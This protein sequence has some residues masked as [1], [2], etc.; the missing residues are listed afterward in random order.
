MGYFGVLMLWLRM[1]MLG[2]NVRSVC[3]GISDR[4][5]DLWV[6]VRRIN[7]RA[8][9]LPSQ[10]LYPIPKTPDTILPHPVRKSK[11]PTFS[12]PSTHAQSAPRAI[13]SPLFLYHSPSHEHKPS[14]AA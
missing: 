11:N 9:S 13:T 2:T 6:V 10:T 3:F 14:T 12:F 4:L 1:M 8:M 7:H 5:N